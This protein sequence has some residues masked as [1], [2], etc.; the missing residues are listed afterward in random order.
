MPPSAY[1]LVATF[2]AISLIAGAAAARILRPSRWWAALLPAAAAF[3]A[4][5]LVGHRWVVTI[6]PEVTMWGWKVALPFDVVVAIGAAL[7]VASLQRGALALL[8]SQERGPG[9]DGL[10]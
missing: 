6:G 10:A 8:E 5:Y 9:R 4:L 3:G 1:A 2:A 7:V